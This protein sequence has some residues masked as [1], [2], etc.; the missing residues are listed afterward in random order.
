MIASV[1]IHNDEDYEAAK[2]TRDHLWGIDDDHPQAEYLE[3]LLKAIDD[4]ERKHRRR[5]DS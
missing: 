4:Y 2:K 3:K 1:I 5:Y